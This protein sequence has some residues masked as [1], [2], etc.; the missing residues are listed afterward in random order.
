MRTDGLWRRLSRGA[1]MEITNGLTGMWV[2]LEEVRGNF[3]LLEELG[4]SEV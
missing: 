3:I 2:G 4:V 1:R